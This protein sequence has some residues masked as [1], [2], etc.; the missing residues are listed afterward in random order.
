MLMKNTAVVTILTN[1]GIEKSLKKEE[2]ELIRTPVGDKYIS[3]LLKEKGYSIGGEQSG[4]IIFN[5]YGTT[6]DGILTAIKLLEVL[7]DKK[8]TC[9]LLYSGLEMYL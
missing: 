3:Q 6:G 7:A 8:S 5:K 4:H 9:S 1:I 2:I